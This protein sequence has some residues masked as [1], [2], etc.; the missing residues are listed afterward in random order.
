MNR[1][2]NVR[3]ARRDA[4]FWVGIEGGVEVFEEE[5]EAFGWMVILSDDRIGKARSCTFPLPPYIAK[6][7]LEGKE[8][9]HINDEFFSNAQFQTRRRRSW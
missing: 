2:E 5:M 6:A 8:L 4:D 9:G 7:V 3:L 1:A